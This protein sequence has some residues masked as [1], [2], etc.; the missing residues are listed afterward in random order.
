MSKNRHGIGQVRRVHVHLPLHLPSAFGTMDPAHLRARSCCAAVPQY[1]YSRE[2][3]ECLAW[4]RM[5]RRCSSRYGRGFPHRSLSRLRIGHLHP[6]GPVR[7]RERGQ[8][9]HQGDAEPVGAERPLRRC[10]ARRLRTRH[11][12]PATR[13]AGGRPERPPGPSRTTA[14]D[15]LDLA[16]GVRGARPQPGEPCRCRGRGLRGVGPGTVPGGVVQRQLGLASVP[17]PGAENPSAG[18]P[19][20]RGKV[21][22][23]L[24]RLSG[25]A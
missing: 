20:P 22:W 21:V 15:A 6:S 1:R 3:R 23:A 18:A 5:D 17:V 13:A 7:S 8:A 9:V 10:R 16:T 14:P 11:Q 19:A 12:R 25:D 24:F 2:S 4:G